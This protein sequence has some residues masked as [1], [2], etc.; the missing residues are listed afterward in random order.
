MDEWQPILM[1]PRDGTEIT[2]LTVGGYELLA[3]W[4]GGLVDEEEK[5][6]GGWHAPLDGDH[7]ECWTDGI[8]WFSNENETPSDAPIKWLCRLN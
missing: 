3:F 7:P 6:C 1:A 2:V 8:C 4:G 5:E